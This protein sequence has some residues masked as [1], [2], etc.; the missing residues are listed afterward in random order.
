M[1]LRDRKM[2]FR[3]RPIASPAKFS[4]SMSFWID[5]LKYWGR[6]RQKGA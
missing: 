3:R 5:E 2:R 4:D 1:A 6:E